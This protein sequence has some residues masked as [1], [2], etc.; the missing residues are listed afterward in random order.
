MVRA[1]Q[2]LMFGKLTQKQIPLQLILATNKD[3]KDAR[4]QHVLAVQ[5][6]QEIVIAGV[7]VIMHMQME[8][9]ISMVLDPHLRLIPP[10]PSL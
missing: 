5:I 2:S 10:N 7:A 9:K 6:H 8:T 1:V 4:G 3:I